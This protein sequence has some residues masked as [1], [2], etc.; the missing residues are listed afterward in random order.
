MNV[1]KLKKGPND[2]SKMNQMTLTKGLNDHLESAILIEF[3]SKRTN[4]HLNFG[5]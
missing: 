2:I 3:H 1:N 4:D 5:L